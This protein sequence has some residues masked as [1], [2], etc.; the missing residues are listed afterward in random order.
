MFYRCLSL[1]LFSKRSSNKVEELIR[2][3]GK[4]KRPKEAHTLQEPL[5][6]IKH[7]KRVEWLLVLSLVVHMSLTPMNHK[8]NGEYLQEIE[9]LHK[10]SCWG[11]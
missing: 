3:M 1:T 10:T 5:G 11:K 7:I 2:E 6:M 4:P 9:I 8:Y